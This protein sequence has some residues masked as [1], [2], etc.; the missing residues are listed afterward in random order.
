MWGLRVQLQRV[1]VQLHMFVS[2]AA[3]VGGNAGLVIREWGPGGAGF[4][5]ALHSPCQRRI[6]AAVQMVGS[7]SNHLQ[8]SVFLA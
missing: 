2:A 7:G 8:R 4:S 3:Q 1:R 5:G 6:Q